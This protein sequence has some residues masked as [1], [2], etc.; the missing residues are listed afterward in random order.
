[1]I[2]AYARKS[3]LGPYIVINIPSYGQLIS[4]AG[5]STLQHLRLQDIAILMYKIKHNMCPTYIST[6]FEQPA[7]KY[8]LCNHDFTI[9]RFN[10]VSFGKH[11]PRYMG[12]RCGA[13]FPVK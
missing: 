13:L 7:I 4:M 1:M 6:L 5:L 3:T 12:Q 11:L 10:T 8:K 2:R 9:P